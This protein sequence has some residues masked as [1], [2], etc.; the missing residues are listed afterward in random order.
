MR[1]L[2]QTPPTE[3][4]SHPD[5]VKPSKANN[6]TYM[7]ACNS[8]DNQKFAS[9]EEFVTRGLDERLFHLFF[10]DPKE[11]ASNLLQIKAVRVAVIG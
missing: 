1:G 6:S 2:N 7:A 8:R 5:A 10:P 9:I 3:N 11:D 4:T